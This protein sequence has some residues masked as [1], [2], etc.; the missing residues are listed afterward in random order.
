MGCIREV[1]AYLGVER[2]TTNHREKLLSALGAALA[3]VAVYWAT[4]RTLAAGLIDI[5]T[6]YFIIASMGASAVLLF[7]VP[8]GALSQPRRFRSR[9]LSSTLPPRD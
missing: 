3:I 1:R 5:P 6:S 7:A 8:H 9:I 4:Q 2:N